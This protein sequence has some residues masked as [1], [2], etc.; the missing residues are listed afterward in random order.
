MDA[1]ALTEHGNVSSH[2]KLEIAAREHGIKP[3]FGLEAYTAL[4]S[5][6]EDKNTR[7]WHQ[8]LLAE[9]LEGLQRLYNLTSRSWAEGFYRWPTITL[10]MYRD[11]T[12]GLIAT[13]GCLDGKVACDLMGGK[14]NEEPSKKKA[15]ASLRRFMEL[16]PGS[17]YLETQMFPGL[18]R[19]R[20]YNPQ[21]EEWSKKFKIPL[22][23]TGDCHYP[24]PEDN[25]IQKILHAAGRNTGTVAAAEAEWEYDILLTHPESDAFVIKQLRGTGLSKI[26]A[27][28]ALANTQEVAQ[29]CNVELPKM[30]RVRYPCSQEDMLPWT[31]NENLTSTTRHA[32]IAIPTTTGAP[33]AGRPRRTQRRAASGR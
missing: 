30:D 4:P 14:G 3:I 9:S 1:L 7:K 26:A 29:R 11:G 8:T 33:A 18:E 15:E 28:Q 12:S 24:R 22:L 32:G 23:A 5:M 16:F 2:V 17:F 31:A 6:R 27:E 21:L 25:E 13:T 20:E 10:D 19:A